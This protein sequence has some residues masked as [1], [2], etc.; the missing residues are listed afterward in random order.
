[1]SKTMANGTTKMFLLNPNIGSKNMY[2]DKTIR[3]FTASPIVGKN[4][5]VG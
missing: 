4:W 3:A 2:L 5:K 1:M